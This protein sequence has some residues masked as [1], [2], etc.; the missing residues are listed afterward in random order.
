MKKRFLFFVAAVSCLLFGTWSARAVELSDGAVI[1]IGTEQLIHEDISNWNPTGKSAG[2][3]RYDET[4]HTLT[5]DGATITQELFIDSSD[6]GGFAVTI[7]VVG[8]NYI[9]V[10]NANK[11]N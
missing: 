7:Q 2:S 11:P 6:K 5:L 9:Q 8:S 10:T 4:T 1:K 3:I